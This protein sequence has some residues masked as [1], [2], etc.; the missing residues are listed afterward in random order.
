MKA[1]GFVNKEMAVTNLKAKDCDSR[2][3]VGRRIYLQQDGSPVALL[4][5]RTNNPANWC[6]QTAKASMFFLSEQEAVDYCRQRGY[7]LVLPE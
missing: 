6:V 2:S 4:R 5:S 1:S 3:Y 7:K